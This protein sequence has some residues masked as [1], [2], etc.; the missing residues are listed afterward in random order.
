MVGAQAYA[1]AMSM[2]MS[3]SMSH[4]PCPMHLGR[5]AE[6]A[7]DAGDE[8]GSLLEEESVDCGVVLHVRVGIGAGGEERRHSARRVE[9][10][11]QALVHCRLMELQPCEEVAGALVP[12]GA[13]LQPRLA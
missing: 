11:A 2:S 1:Y 5:H 3:M 4:V 7:Q 12:R 9:V 6:D 13:P 8:G 10:V